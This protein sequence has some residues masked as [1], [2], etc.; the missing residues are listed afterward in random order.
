MPDRM[1]VAAGSVEAVMEKVLTGYLPRFRATS[2][3]SHLCSACMTLK[4][5][6]RTWSLCY[7]SFEGDGFSL[8]T[9]L[10]PAS[11]M[12]AGKS[13]FDASTRLTAR[14]RLAVTHLTH[15][16]RFAPEAAP[17]AASV[18]APGAASVAAPGAAS[19]AA[20]GAAS[21]AAPGAASVAAPEA[22]SVAA[23]DFAW[24]PNL[25]STD[26]DVCGEHAFRSP[27][28]IVR[29]NGVQIALVPS[30]EPSRNGG[31]LHRTLS[32]RRGGG[33]DLLSFLLQDCAP[34]DHVYYAPTDRPVTLEAGESAELR[35]TLLFDLEA[36]GSAH[37]TV[38]RFLWKR[39]GEPAFRSTMAPQVLPFGEYAR[40]SYGSTLDTYGLWRSFS[41]DGKE[42]G[43]TCARIMRPSLDGG[44]LPLPGDI[45]PAIIRNY[46]LTPTM[47]LRDKI[48][49]ARE[50]ARG[51]HPHVW[52]NT[53]FNQIR[54]SFGMNWWARRWKDTALMER[55]IRMRNLALAAPVSGGIF[56][57]VFTADGRSPHW[58]PG[59]RV[60][61]YTASYHT[62]DAAWTG[63]WML[64][65]CRILGKEQALMARCVELGRFFRRVQ[66][67]SGAIPTWVK[68]S[69]SGRV[70]PEAALRESASS[71][72]AGMFLASLAETTGEASWMEAARAVAE[73][74]IRAVLPGSLWQ[75]AE[76]FFS[77]SPKRLD[78]RDP[79]TGIPPQGSLSLGWT[80]ELL[81]T[82]A[83]ATGEE[84][85]R[86]HGRAVLDLLL[87]YQQVWN[88]PFIGFHA[89][90]GFGAINTDSEW[91]DA[92]Q[93]QFATLLMDWYAL[94][95]EPELF[96]RGVA[97][98]RASFALMHMEEHRS[99][100]PG[101]MAGVGEADRGALPENYG[102]AGRDA[103][104]PGYIMP[105][106][107]GGSAASSAALA[108]E[109]YGDLYVDAGR[110]QAFGVNGCRVLEARF[111][112]GS[113]ELDVERIADH[114]APLMLRA[115]GIVELTSV[116]VNGRDQGAFPA[117]VWERGIPLKEES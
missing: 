83:A 75:D 73:F 60:W 66:L 58:V 63:W 32:L 107:G 95:G 52:N 31:P 1:T 62:P 79:R 17:G 34:H 91:S 27:C 14:K 102:H 112:P 115:C 89:F 35:F 87:L 105:D 56:P 45:T 30:L 53:F 48:T 7:G 61:R 39:H 59:T 108:L 99:L 3:G 65:T 2:D 5:D 70:G 103:K 50:N 28:I 104:I 26:R 76:V 106:W 23:P 15:G 97:A 111:R 12:A 80:A 20:P 4:A 67:P 71:A 57:S 51:I 78:W 117:A 44:S 110:E 36:D 38:L 100:A 109:R 88:P 93:A 74:L 10:T 101:N 49:L 96:Q 113:V 114:G 98:L 25:C 94:T 11:G 68:V 37:G 24:I 43:G 47:R 40:A 13:G 55:A 33:A 41:I 42:C 84:R 6:G 86:A 77:C 9:T 85:W 64:Q 16:F 19:V 69:R 22:A 81:R 72:A 29:R 21:V 46:L 82:L 54:T 92:R 90:G 116:T 8:N 18:A